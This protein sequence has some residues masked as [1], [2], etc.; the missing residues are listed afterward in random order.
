MSGPASVELSAEVPPRC[1]RLLAHAERDPRRAAALARRW[2]ARAA[3]RPPFE[4]AIAT[5]SLGYTLLRWER[6]DQAGPLLD[7]AQALLETLGH[8]MLGLH[9]QRALLFLSLMRGGS[10]HHADEWAALAARYD[11]LGDPLSAARS[12]LAQVGHLSVQG[13]AAA[14]LELAARIRPVLDQHGSPGDRAWLYRFSG[15]ASIS[16]AAFDAALSYLDQAAALFEPLGQ[17]IELAKVWLNQ[18]TLYERRGEP[19]QAIA[20]VE[21]AYQLIQRLD[22]PLRAAFCLKNLGIF[23]T[24]QG[25]YDRGILLSLQAAAMFASLHRHDSL[26]D[27]DLNL[28]NIAY[29]AGL[30]DLALAAYQRAEHSFAVLGYKQMELICQRNQAMALRLRGEPEV[31]LQRLQ[32]LINLAEQLNEQLELAWISLTQAQAYADLG[33]LAPAEQAFALA[34]T[35]FRALGNPS[36]AGESLLDWGWLLLRQ[37]L[38]VQAEQLL[39]TAHPLLNEQPIYQWRAE[40]GLGRCAEQRGE[41]AAARERYQRA[42]LIVAQLRQRLANEHA[43]SGLFTQARQLM[44]DAIRLAWQL[45]EPEQLLDLAELQRALALVA[46]MREAQVQTLAQALPIG[47]PAQ[48]LARELVAAEVGGPGQPELQSYLEQRLRRRRAPPP[49]S[50]PLARLSLTELRAAFQQAFP[51]GWTLLVY[52]PCAEQLLTLIVE[53][54]QIA[55]VSTAFD[56]QLQQLVKRATAEPYRPLTYLGEQDAAW[57]TLSALGER[58]IPAQLRE[59]LHPAQRLLIVA[60]GALHSMPWAALRLGGRWLVEQSTPQQLPGL[61]IWQALRLR[62]PP[63]DAALLVGVSRFGARADDLAGVLPTLAIVESRWP[64]QATRLEETAASV[65]ELLKRAGRAE[66][67]RYGLIHFAT[68]GRLAPASGLLAELKLADGELRYD[69]IVQLGL[70]GALVVLAACEGAAAEVLPGD[71]LLSLSWAFL[72][73]GARDV[74]A[75]L[76]QLYDTMAPQLIDAL[77]AQLASGQPAPLALAEA[78]RA[79]LRRRSADQEFDELA[80]SPLVWAGLSAIGAG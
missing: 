74:I 1:A 51:A 37:G 38:F 36:A 20:Y 67:R 52:L 6:F 42:C 17:R 62:Q 24:L 40:H 75:S 49:V 70:G 53:P 15:I 14:A 31:A 80:H 13:H 61:L 30:W 45:D 68:H 18:S 57:P 19:A 23:Y 21:R 29:Y 58:L 60:N 10:A 59:R 8:Q 66:L 25:E 64:G 32:T 26:A 41:L 71:E 33:Q 78:Q 44:D 27:C 11:G 35:Q 56:T 55:I 72:A 2:Q 7:Q 12:R 47:P 54:A 4:R 16:Q 77:Y 46:S 5:Y 65:V 48:P 79:W 63:G 76:W 39:H 22:L 73:A 28:G 9:V 50:E 34:E 69:D 3:R 43:S